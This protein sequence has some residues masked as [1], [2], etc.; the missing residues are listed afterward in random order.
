MQKHTT[1][2]RLSLKQLE[3]IYRL[4]A[5]PVFVSHDAYFIDCFLSAKRGDVQDRHQSAGRLP[6]QQLDHRAGLGLH[7]EECE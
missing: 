7:P 3:Q 4:H 5:E 6:R 2:L 1:C